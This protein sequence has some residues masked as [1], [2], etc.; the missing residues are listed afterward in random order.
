MSSFLD[1][2]KLTGGQTN[3]FADRYQGGQGRG[4]SD[5]PFVKGY[6]FV[7]FGLPSTLFGS[8]G[9]TNATA[10]NYLLSSAEG[11]TPHADR[12]IVTQDT[13]GMGGAGGASFITGQQISRDFSIQYKDY[14]GSPIFRVHRTWTGYLDPY[15]GVSVK[16]KNFSASEYKGTCMVIQT[17]PVARKVGENQEP[18]SDKDIIKVF[19]YDGVQCLTDF[20]SIYD[21]NIA[22]NSFVKPTA[23]Y[24]FD[25]YPLTELNED[26]LNSAVTILNN[27]SIFANTES[28]Y[29]NLVSDTNAGNGMTPSFG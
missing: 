12:Q 27:A 29:N 20:N 21:S 2:I 24:K 11:F 10:K 6:F 4:E 7:F 5:H 23:Q 18:W 13:Q 17:K 22:D 1:N 26:V 14:W 3:V 15:L 8:G 25:G 16:A 9:I 19:F 28:I